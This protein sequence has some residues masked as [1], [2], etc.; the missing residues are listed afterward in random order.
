MNDGTPPVRPGYGTRGTPVILW[1]NFF[2]LIT[3][4]DVPVYRYDILVAPEEK[5]KKHEQLVKLFLA[6][7][8]LA[9]TGIVT[10]FKVSGTEHSANASY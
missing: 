10:D 7:L 2:E 3:K 4:K 9:S 8:K 1:A 6:E 5:G